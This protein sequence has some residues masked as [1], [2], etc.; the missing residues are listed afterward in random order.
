MVMVMV[1]VRVRVMVTVMVTDMVDLCMPSCFH[2]HLP[3]GY[4]QAY[5]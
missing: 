3:Q 1:M 5:Y 4:N 2:R